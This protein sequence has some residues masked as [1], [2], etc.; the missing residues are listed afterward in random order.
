MQAFGKFKDL[1]TRDIQ[2]FLDSEPLGR[3]LTEV[4]NASPQRR[5]PH[6][7]MIKH[8][9][10]GPMKFHL[11]P[12]RTSLFGKALLALMLAPISLN[13][14]CSS[15]A[16]VMCRS[17]GLSVARQHQ[18]LVEDISLLT[19]ANMCATRQN[20]SQ[21]TGTATCSQTM[22]AKWRPLVKHGNTVMSSHVAKPRFSAAGI[23]F[24]GPG[25]RLRGPQRTF[26]GF[27]S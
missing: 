12:P 2:H 5:R 24:F 25:L 8:R 15:P 20:N 10:C 13:C 22:T 19:V 9:V 26:E 14:A 16:G 27:R 23:C 7:R 1:K 3:A 4:Q 6:C 21:P 18:R 17:Q 11:S